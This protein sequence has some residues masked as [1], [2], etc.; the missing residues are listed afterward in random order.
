MLQ[1]QSVDI[2]LKAGENDKLELSTRYTLKYFTFCNF[3][4]TP[5][6]NYLFN[7]RLEIH[8]DYSM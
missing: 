8:Y 4:I 6:I 2:R 7:I 5:V 3:S 1:I